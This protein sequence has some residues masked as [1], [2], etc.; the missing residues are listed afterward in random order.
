M[1]IAVDDPYRPDVLA[2]LEEH[3]AE[4]RFHSPPESVHAL[5]PAALASPGVTFCAARDDA[6]VLLGCGALSRLSAEHGEIKSM[7]T[8]TAARRRGVAAAV[9]GHLVDLGR[10]RGY[11]RVSLETGTQDVF[12]PARRLYAAHGFTE[13]GPF[14]GYRLDVYSCFMTLGLDP[15]DGPQRQGLQVA[16]TGAAATV[17]GVEPQA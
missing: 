8:S 6:G 16:S 17:A 14:G 1:R 12:E 10:R 11:S 4:M 3:L 2:L 13:C 7:R 15:D 9:L 5:D